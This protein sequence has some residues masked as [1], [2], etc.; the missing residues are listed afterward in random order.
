MRII[1][2]ILV[3]I[4]TAMPITGWAG[5]FA[6]NENSAADM[7]RAN[8]GRVTHIQDASASYGNPAL[9]VQYLSLI[10]I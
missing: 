4:T 8:A 10:H 1:K 7:G 3:S 2:I 9:M 5:G 6:I